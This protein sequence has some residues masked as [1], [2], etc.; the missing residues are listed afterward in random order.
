MEN[1]GSALPD[2]I[3]ETIARVIYLVE[4]EK[5]RYSWILSRKA[6]GFSIVIKQTPNVTATRKHKAPRRKR[7]DVNARKV[8]TVSKEPDSDAT[9]IPALPKRRKHK[10]PSK[11][12]RDRSRRK[13]YRLRKRELRAERPSAN[14]IAAEAEVDSSNCVQEPNASVDHT[15]EKSSSSQVNIPPHACDNLPL[16]VCVSS[17]NTEI[18]SDVDSNFSE[19][20]TVNIKTCVHCKKEIQET[21]I[22]CSRCQSSSYCSTECQAKDWTVWH[23]FACKSSL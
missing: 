18:D 16:E 7:V 10:T 11:L 15:V 22:N 4:R 12:A 14:A 3:P 6:D 5:D 2:L 23:K 19:Q 17:I 20:D 9:S 21:P 1:V 8:N 13:L